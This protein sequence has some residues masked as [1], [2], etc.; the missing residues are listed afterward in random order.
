M[1]PEI[2]LCI[3][4]CARPTGL[5]RLLASI[6][7]LEL[8]SGVEIE[9]VV[10]DND[11]AG[12][13]APVLARWSHLPGLRTFHEPERNIARARN[14]AVREARG[15]WLAFVDDDEAV[16]PD[17]LVAHWRQLELAPCDGC[18]GPVLPRLEQVVTP[19]LDP[20]A[21]FAG[22]RFPSGAVVGPGSMATNN[23]L[24]SAEL[25]RD[26]AF[27]PKLGLTPSPAAKCGAVISQLFCDWIEARTAPAIGA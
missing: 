16:Q 24:L 15:R 20:A 2:S 26:R 12:T 4:T 18:F 25:F 19:W 9:V 6:E 5:A 13:A 7:Q 27:D 1:A 11:P 14:R 17:W 8:P 21:F 23:A 3:A 10:V 22:P